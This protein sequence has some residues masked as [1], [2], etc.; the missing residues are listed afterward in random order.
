MDENK[1][2]NTP[3]EELTSVTSTPQELD[4]PETALEFVPK[5]TRWVKI[6]SFFGLKPK[7]DTSLRETLEEY[8]ESEDNK[9]ESAPLSTHEKDLLSNVLELHTMCANDVMIPRADIVGIPNDITHEELFAFLTSKQYSRF[10]VYNETLDNI[11]GVIHIK[12]ILAA[13]VRGKEIDIKTLIREIPIISPSMHVLDL[14]TQMRLT[15]K[16]IVL[17]VDEFGGIDGL[18]T[19]G[20]LIEAI[21]GEINDEHN[22]DIQPEMTLQSDGSMIADARYD[23]DEF[24]DIYEHV[25][26]KEEREETETLGGLMSFLVGRVPA[27]GEVIKHS[28]DIVFEIIDADPRRVKRLCIR[29]L[30]QSQNKK[31]P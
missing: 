20:D 10:P 19:I 30:P 16:H 4:V 25:L 6:K 8:I 21:V 29:N 13:V 23:I 22:P 15:R 3:K 9:E 18:I 5:E 2:E 31:T 17:V 27:R 26:T 14:L 1:N 28:S 11:V 24:E 12:D 7:N